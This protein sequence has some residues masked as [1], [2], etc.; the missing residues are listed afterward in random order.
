MLRGCHAYQAVKN[1]GLKL[2]YLTRVEKGENTLQQ[3]GV[4][5]VCLNVD[6]M[7]PD[8]KHHQP[9]PAFYAEFF[10]KRIAVTVDSA[11]A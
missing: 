9:H 7:V 11:G 10:E 5:T 1:S 3:G 6:E 8:G 2:T 4:F